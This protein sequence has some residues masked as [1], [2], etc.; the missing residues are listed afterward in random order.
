MVVWAAKAH[1]CQDTLLF[2]VSPSK[3]SVVMTKKALGMI[4]NLTKCVEIIMGGQQK[5]IVFNIFLNYLNSHNLCTLN[6][7]AKYVPRRISGHKI[8][9]AKEFDGTSASKYIYI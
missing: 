2:P 7:N 8:C 5:I 6:S 4:T 9:I 1:I 3:T